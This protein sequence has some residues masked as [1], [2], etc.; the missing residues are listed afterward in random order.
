MSPATAIALLHEIITTLPAAI[1]TGQQVIDLVNHTWNSR[2][3]ASEAEL[4]R[5]IVANSKEIQST[6]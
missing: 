4:V 6:G 3:T 5:E 1:T 2:A